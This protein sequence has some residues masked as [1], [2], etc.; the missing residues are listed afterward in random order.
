MSL[1]TI[2]LT[3]EELSTKRLSPYHLQ[4]ALEALHR[5]GIVVLTNAIRPVDA[6]DKLNA[7]MVP[8]A[9]Q[10]F[11]DGATQR[12]FGEATGNIQQEPPMRAD[13]LFPSVVANPF[14]TE[15]VSCIVGPEPCLRYYSANTLFRT[16][17]QGRQPPH[18][19]IN[20]PCPVMPFG[21][22]ISIYLVDVGP[23]NGA[24][25]FWPGSHKVVA[26]FNHVVPEE[27]LEQRRK[28]APPVQP[29]LPR[30]SLVIRDFKLWHAG[31][32]N[33][34]DEPRVMLGTALLA[35]WWQCKMTTPWP[36]TLA[37]KD[38]FDWGGVTPCLRFVE[39][40]EEYKRDVA[41]GDYDFSQV[42]ERPAEENSTE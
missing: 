6:L 27:L 21:Y 42:L 3:A 14:A 24:T 16:E 32:P 37:D 2:T 41:K 40:G 13:L 38:A 5:D 34:T 1:P 9:R 26:D 35:R 18:V 31:L 36:K 23:E 22:L 30:G 10:L 33:K 15:I 39:E 4:T 28:I 29:T 20:F 8:R 7:E 12:N 25:E 11:A 17:T 19:D